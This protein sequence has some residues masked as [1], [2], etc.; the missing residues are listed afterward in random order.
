MYAACGGCGGASGGCGGATYGGVG[1]HC[2]GGAAW[3]LLAAPS[4]LSLM[5]M[6]FVMREIGRASCRGGGCLSP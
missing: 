1:A 4:L 6:R 5:D 3:V 2:G